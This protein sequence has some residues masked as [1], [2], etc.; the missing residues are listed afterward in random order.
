M[1]LPILLL[2]A[3]MTGAPALAEGPWREAMMSGSQRLMLYTLSES[4]PAGSERFIGQLLTQ[5]GA[6]PAP[7]PPRFS[8]YIRPLLSWDNNFNNRIPGNSFKLGQL[9]FIVDP[10]S[11]AIG[12]LVLGAEAGGQGVWR[13]GFGS[14]LTLGGWASVET[15]PRKNMV[16]RGAGAALCYAGYQGNW[17]WIDLC[18]RLRLS[19]LPLDPVDRETRL[20]AGVTRL[21]T[22][23][24][25]AHEASFT[26]AS[27]KGS[28]AARPSVTLGLTSALADVGATRVQVEFAKKIKGQHGRVF[29]LSAGLSKPL[30]GEVTD[31]DLS[32]ARNSGG[33]V[34]G[35]PRVDRRYAVS[36]SR[37]VSERLSASLGYFRTDSTADVFDDKGLNLNFQLRPW[38]F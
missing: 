32:F 34:F 10:D 24:G 16:R 17:T 5:I 25:A 23:P 33:T 22:A 4:A 30:W 35:T 21:F 13:V 37:P 28:D 11:R 31:I 18:G 20:S 1:R 9:E 6:T 7:V 8:G 2:M 29:A 27:T 14:T 36:V 19:D 15:L 26:L 38:T 12:G 3:A